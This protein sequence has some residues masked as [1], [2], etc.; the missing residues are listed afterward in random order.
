MESI[1][2]A[3][4]VEHYDNGKGFYI[5]YPVKRVI[6]VDGELLETY[7][8]DHVGYDF[9]RAPGPKAPSVGM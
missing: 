1:L 6:E 7:S 2:K 9:C 8:F 3:E 5:D 4:R